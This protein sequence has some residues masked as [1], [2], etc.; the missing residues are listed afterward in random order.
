MNLSTFT[1]VG[2]KPSATRRPTKAKG[3]SMARKKKATA[4]RGRARVAN[5]RD[6]PPVK[7]PSRGVPVVEASHPVD[8]AIDRF[9]SHDARL[10]DAMSRNLKERS[11]PALNAAARA[12][13]AFARFAPSKYS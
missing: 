4:T 1:Q 2:Y 7:P 11:A 10:R 8:D 9:F 13:A 12:K 5:G 6:I 3:C